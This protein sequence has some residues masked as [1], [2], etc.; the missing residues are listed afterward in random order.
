[1][2][3]FLNIFLVIFLLITT[4]IFAG[5]RIW[6]QVCAKDFENGE[7]KGTQLNADG[8][9]CLGFELQKIKVSETSIWS[10]VYDTEGNLYFGTGT[11][12][13]IYRLPKAQSSENILETKEYFKTDALLVTSLVIEKNFL[14]AATLPEGK[15]FQINLA[16]GEGKI[17]ATL[18][19]GYIW[20]LAICNNYLIAAT[21]PDGILYKISLDSAKAEVLLKTKEKHLLSLAID[22][23]QNIY[24]G[25]DPNGLFI[26]I[27]QTG[28][29]TVLADLTENEIR[30]IAL[31]NGKIYLGAN[32]TKSFDNAKIVQDLAQEIEAQAKKNKSVNRKEL[33][34]KMTSGAIYEFQENIGIRSLLPLPKN[35]VTTLAAYKDGVLVGT[36][37]DGFVYHAVAPEKTT[38]A[39]DLREDQ[40][41]SLVIYNQELQFLGTGDTGILYRLAIPQ[42]ESY[43][44]SSILDAT[45]LSKWGKVDWKKRGALNLQTRSGNTQTPDMFWSDWTNLVYGKIASPNARYFQ[46]RVVWLD[47]KGNEEFI[48]QGILESVRVYYNPINR[49]PVISSFK[50]EGPKE[51]NSRLYSLKIDKKLKISWKGEDEDKDELIYSL[52]YRNVESPTL[53]E[54]SATEVLT[55]AN[56]TWDTSVLPDGYYHFIIV[57][58]DESNN[59]IPAKTTYV[60]SP[61]LVDNQSPVII[62]QRIENKLIGKAYDSFSCI[63]KVS[64]RLGNTPWKI[65]EPEDSI[66]D[67]S[68]ENF[69]INLPE[70]FAKDNT[71]I[72]IRA[73]D[74]NGNESYRLIVK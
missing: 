2:K 3:I 74:A 55:K 61:I 33:L 66:Y 71:T 32:V 51:D 50:V 68:T 63:A 29:A 40:V 52:Y 60:S 34:Q 13:K 36:G 8:T 10:Y 43:F 59:I 12:G 64:Y 48:P 44:Y 30:S 56:Y 1:M 54:I 27:S 46:Y 41:M 62:V 69:V 28:Q 17:W 57:A 70:N 26:K 39:I 47:I 15:I 18:A 53:Y 73:T 35:I 49:P 21:G 6:E 31:G 7:F 42:S 38:L 22:N 37:M 19:S 9:I 25:T 14:Y 11:K 5:T 16:T 23:A 65:A 67:D 4:S 24:V 20:G 58:S 45:G 72:E